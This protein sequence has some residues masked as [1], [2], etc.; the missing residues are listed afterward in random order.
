MVKNR[1]FFS[2]L[3]PSSEEP[4][5]EDYESVVEV[6]IS[7]CCTTAQCVCDV[8][9]CSTGV[10]VC[11]GNKH[12]EVTLANECCETAKCVCNEC[13]EPQICKEGWTADEE[14][15]DCGCIKRKLFWYGYLRFD[16]CFDYTV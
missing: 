12:V 14:T 2:S 8:S 13:M 15:D 9:K 10:T 7:S 6:P 1:F 5:C 16:I 3:C 4:N 11:A